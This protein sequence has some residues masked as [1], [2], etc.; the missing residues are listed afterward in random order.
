MTDACGLAQA[1]REVTRALPFVLLLV[2][3]TTPRPRCDG[4]CA[5]APAADVAEADVVALDDVAMETD[6]SDD[7]DGAV[8]GGALDAG[9]PDAPADACIEHWVCEPWTTSGSTDAATR[10]CR[11]LSA[12]GT[13]ASR[14]VLTATL[15]PLDYEYFECN[16]QPILDR[17][18]AQ[19]ACHGVER[20]RSLRIYARGRHRLATGSFV[21][22]GCGARMGMTGSLAECEGSLECGCWTLGRTDV[23]WRRNYDAARGLALDASGAALS[24]PAASELLD[25]PRIGG[26]APHDGVAFWDTTDPEYATIRQWLEGTRLGRVCNSGS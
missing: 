13:T 22:P 12:C 8:D 17:G 19:L 24:D 25:R 7:R 3:C 15:P 6:A 16:V 5:D 26:T 18:C 23:E 10:T 14:P 4:G 21:E 2:A 11:D 9:V 1:H 20:G